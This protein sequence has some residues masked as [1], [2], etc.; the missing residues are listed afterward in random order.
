MGPDL[1]PPM[2]AVAARGNPVRMAFVYHLCADDFRG[3][4][5]L[6]CMPCGQ[7]TRMYTTGSG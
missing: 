4:E 1:L 3:S 5:L 7:L 2:V 6:P